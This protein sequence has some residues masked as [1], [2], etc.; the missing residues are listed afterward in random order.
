MT[1][2]HTFAR[3]L[4]I[5]F[6]LFGLGCVAG[7]LLAA[8]QPGGADALLPGVLVG[9]VWTVIG[10]KGGL[11][12]MSLGTGSVS[13]Q[14]D[15]LK[16]RVVLYYLLSVAWL[17]LLVLGTLAAPLD[18]RFSAFVL[19]AVPLVTVYIWCWFAVCPQCGKHFFIPRPTFREMYASKRFSACRHCGVSWKHREAPV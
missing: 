6:T 19:L 16:R 9:G 8:V 7:S 11:P 13:S 2:S 18:W 10:V 15:V 4:R 17:P 14:L 5:A 12:L 3:W 1:W